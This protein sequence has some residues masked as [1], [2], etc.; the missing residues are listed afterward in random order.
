MSQSGQRRANNGQY[1]PDINREHLSPVA[2]MVHQVLNEAFE[3]IRQNFTIMNEDSSNGDS[4]V[5]DSS[6]NRKQIE[7]V[8]Q[9]YFGKSG[10]KACATIL[11]EPSPYNAFYSD[12]YTRVAEEV[13]KQEHNYVSS[14]LSFVI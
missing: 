1:Q 14:L 3:T 13:Q 4:S 8:L 10:S 2:K 5:A 11:R 9:E 7:E 12:N 6:T